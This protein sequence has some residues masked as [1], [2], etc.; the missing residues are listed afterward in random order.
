MYQGMPHAGGNDRSGL[1]F[2]HP[3]RREGSMLNDRRPSRPSGPAQQMP[4]ASEQELFPGMVRNRES[5][6]QLW[7]HVAQV[8]SDGVRNK[9]LMGEDSQQASPAGL[10]RPSEWAG[11][12][13]WDRGPEDMVDST[14]YRYS[15][16]EIR[17]FAPEGMPRRDT[18]AR[19]FRIGD[20]QIAE[21]AL[22]AGFDEE[23][24]AIAVAVA[25][26]ESGGSTAAVGDAKL[27][28]RKWGSSL[29]LWQIRSLHDPARWGSRTDLMRDSSRLFDPQFNAEAAFA[30]SSGGSNWDPWTVYK[31]GA[32]RRYLGRARQ[33]VADAGG[34][35]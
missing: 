23:Q 25:L 9:A 20:N 24:A 19:D 16:E 13:S 29:G 1:P 4:A 32:Y 8:L 14:G 18:L 35:R 21:L 5:M 7:T 27:M 26:A 30:I 28:N 22:G 17:Q 31:T 15:E 10:P 33:A 12:D 11:R 3:R 6:S 34:L 2:W